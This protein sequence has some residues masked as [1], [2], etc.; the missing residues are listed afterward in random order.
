MSYHSDLHLE[1]R[2][3]DVDQAEPGPNDMPATADE[4]S[5]AGVNDTSSLEKEITAVVSAKFA[6][7]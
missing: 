2:E 7:E 4:V 1:L 6:L 3:Q 5:G